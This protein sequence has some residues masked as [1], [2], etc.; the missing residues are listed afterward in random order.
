MKLSEHDQAV[1][2]AMRD[3][4]RCV[5]A[6]YAANPA[7]QSIWIDGYIEGVLQSRRPD[8]HGSQTRAA[9]SCI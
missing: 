5:P 7:A 2:T 3:A 9:N 1:V 6:E 4:L 8:E